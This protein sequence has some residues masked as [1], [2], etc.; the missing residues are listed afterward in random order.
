MNRANRV[1]GGSLEGDV[2]GIE[3]AAC[4]GAVDGA[5]WAITSRRLTEDYC[6]EGSSGWVRQV[7]VW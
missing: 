2:Q 7:C 3:V 1:N 5:S 6:Q 4:R